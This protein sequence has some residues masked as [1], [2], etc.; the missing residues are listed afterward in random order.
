MLGL[1]LPAV[2]LRA[3]AQ[4]PLFLVNDN[5]TVS[6]VSFKFVGDQTF[7]DAQLQAQ[8]ATT[9]PGFLDGVGRI[10]PFSLFLTPGV[11]PFDPIALAKD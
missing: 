1:L 9:A 4:A 5:T 2:A 10:F 11:Y 3:Q 6:E 7:E 8:I